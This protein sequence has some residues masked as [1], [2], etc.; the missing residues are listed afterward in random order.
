MGAPHAAFFICPQDFCL[1]C[2]VFC[3]IIHLVMTVK[4]LKKLIQY[5]TKGSDYD[6]KTAVSLFQTKRYP[7]SLFFCHLAS[8]KMFKA[9]VVKQSGEHSP[10]THNLLLL[11][12]KSGIE[13]PKDVESLL[14]ELGKFNIEAR[15]PEYTM[16][17]YNVAD[18]TYT[19]RYLKS[20]KRLLEWLRKHL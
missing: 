10:Y 19:N 18:A 6:F 4:D 5:W 14:A 2:G 3:E 1:C 11:A 15:Y 8:E 12:G 7:Y 20:T 9:L 17:L 13:I 16:E